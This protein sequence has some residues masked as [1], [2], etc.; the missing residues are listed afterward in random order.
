M[1]S[2]TA[3]AGQGGIRPCCADPA[4]LGPPTTPD[5]ERPKAT[6]RVC[7]ACGRRHWRLQADPAELILRRPQE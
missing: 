5:P 2:V 6:V 7:R 4:N 3:V 1:I